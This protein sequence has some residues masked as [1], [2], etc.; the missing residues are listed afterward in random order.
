MER[1]RRAAFLPTHPE[2][3]L[4]TVLDAAA[5]VRGGAELAWSADAGHA[6][7]PQPL[8]HLL[9][10]VGEGQADEGL[11]VR[12]GLLG[13]REATGGQEDLDTAVAEDGQEEGHGR[14]GQ[15]QDGDGEVGEGPPDAIGLL[16]GHYPDGG[17]PGLIYT[18]SEKWLVRGGSAQ[19]ARGEAVLRLGLR[20]V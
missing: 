9:L 14:R 5:V 20:T 8:R 6:Q 17:D 12:Q 15:E 2:E 11:A 1:E 19:Q 13:Q 16:L 18:W 7:V 4:N 10:L 3:D